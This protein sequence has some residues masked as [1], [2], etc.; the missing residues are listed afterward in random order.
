LGRP[1][2]PDLNRDG[3]PYGS[4]RVDMPRVILPHVSEDDV[5]P[6][7]EYRPD[8]SLRANQKMLAGGDSGSPLRGWDMGPPPPYPPTIGGGGEVN[9]PDF[10]T[11]DERLKFPVQQTVNNPRLRMLT[12]STATRAEEER[13][14]NQKLQAS[15]V[16]RRKQPT[17]GKSSGPSSASMTA[18]RSRTGTPSTMFDGGATTRSSSVFMEG[19][20][21]TSWAGG[22]AGMAMGSSSSFG[23]GGG[24]GSSR[25]GGSRVSSATYRNWPTMDHMGGGTLADGT[26]GDP[27]VIVVPMKTF[28]KPKQAAKK[29]EQQRKTEEKRRQREEARR[30]RAGLDNE[31]RF[32]YAMRNAHD[33]MNPELF[34]GKDS[35]YH[36]LHYKGQ[37]GPNPAMRALRGGLYMHKLRTNPGRKTHTMMAGIS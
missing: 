37:V 21:S 30:R 34:F 18:T 33:D 22:S 35:S 2:L 6:L 7:A 5:V 23:M 20:A 31:T 25:G 19:D 4:I 11:E 3:V 9:N 16:R 32:D 28:Y 1:E 26:G 29:A 10:M 36:L 8:R 13:K 17:G 24:M 14:A 15:P 12:L 27:S